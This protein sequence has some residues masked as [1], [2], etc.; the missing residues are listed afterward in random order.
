MKVTSIKDVGPVSNLISPSLY[1]IF[2]LTNYALSIHMGQSSYSMSLEW[3]GCHIFGTRATTSSKGFKPSNKKSHIYIYIY[4]FI[5]WAMDIM[6]Y[7]FL[8]RLHINHMKKLQCAFFH[9][10]V[11]TAANS[12]D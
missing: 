12:Q 11:G 3:M 8:C 4:I 5:Y 10:T 2:Q 7:F 9:G 6:D 1:Y